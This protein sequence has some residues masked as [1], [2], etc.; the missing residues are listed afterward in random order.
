MNA[1]SSRSHMVFT[2]TLTQIDLDDDIG[3]TKKVSKLNV[4]DL[5]GSERQDATGAAGK[6][7]KE[8]AQINLSLSMLGKVINSLAKKASFIP[9]RDSK[10][11]RLLQNSLGG[12]S[13]TIMLAAVSPTETNLSESMST[14]RFAE[15]A[16]QIET[17]A[18]I[19]I[20]PAH[21]KLIELLSQVKQLMS[22]NLRLRNQLSRIRA[23]SPELL[24][25]GLDIDDGD[26]DGDGDGGSSGGGGRGVTTEVETQTD[27]MKKQE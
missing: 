11:T 27:A 24:A 12:N 18:K 2:L 17:K 25:D 10:L 4:I 3:Y 26:G 15:R 7:L 14:L 16:K 1:Q 8:G 6:R 22:E 23:K 21:Q 5:A 20:D 19:N 13:V 9:Y